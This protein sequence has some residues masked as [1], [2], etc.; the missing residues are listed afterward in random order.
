VAQEAI[1]LLQPL[2][3]GPHVVSLSSSAP[4]NQAVLLLADAQVSLT[5][6]PGSPPTSRS[7][8][9]LATRTE[10]TAHVV[11]LRSIWPTRLR[12]WAIKAGPLGPSRPTNQELYPCVI[13]RDEPGAAPCESWLSLPSIQVS[14]IDMSSEPDLGALGSDTGGTRGLSRCDCGPMAPQFLTDVPLLPWWSASLWPGCSALQ[15]W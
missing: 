14:V 8:S 3:R 12:P 9:L 13:A 10:E 7:D 1:T 4:R 2:T 11:G 6:F 15:A 5:D